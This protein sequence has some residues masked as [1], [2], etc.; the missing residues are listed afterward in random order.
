MTVIVGVSLIGHSAYYFPVTRSRR[1]WF[2][3]LTGLIVAVCCFVGRVI[4][5]WPVPNNRWAQDTKSICIGM[6][7]DQVATILA[8]S[9]AAR[10]ESC[11]AFKD[12]FTERWELMDGYVDVIYRDNR[13]VY[14]HLRQTNRLLWQLEL[15]ARKLFY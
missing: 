13:V 11:D 8:N 7:A 4:W 5:V 15:V 14:C 9:P 3:F 1:L 10:P 2:I 6:T 12:Q